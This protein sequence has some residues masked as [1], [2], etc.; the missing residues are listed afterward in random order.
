MWVRVLLATVSNI[1]KGVIM[2]D[3]LVGVHK[4]LILNSKHPGFQLAL[5]YTN[6]FE[7]GE[8]TIQ[9]VKMF[10]RLAK[11]YGTETVFFSILDLI[12]M[13][14]LRHNDII[15]LISYFCKKRTLPEAITLYDNLTAKID[16]LNKLEQKMRKDN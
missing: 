4:E 9:Q 8:P 3:S 11:V 16:E 7:L 2:N 5:F 15:R 14:E 13:D 6:V 12:D 10:G 1:Y